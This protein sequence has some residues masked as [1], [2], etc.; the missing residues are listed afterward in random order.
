VETN[1]KSVKDIIRAGR[2]AERSVPVCMRADLVAEHE[3]AERL[4]ERASSEPRSSLGAGSAVSELGERVRALEAE[5]A[6]NTVAFHLRALPRTKWKALIAEHQPRKA[7]DGTV[8]DRDLMGI[9]TDTFF[10]AL[11]RVSVV[12]PELDAEDWA[13]LL[14]ESDDGFALS[15]AQ[16]DALWNT[17]WRLNRNDIDVP[18]S[19]AASRLNQVS[20]SE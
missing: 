20:E 4:R 18:F 17:A 14:G 6:D 8:D 16:F 5:M 15:D 10:E 7:E 11:V 13:I 1:G 12:A 19:P 9:N 3:E 2:L